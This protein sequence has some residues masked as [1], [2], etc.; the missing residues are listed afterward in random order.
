MCIEYSA[1]VAVQLRHKLGQVSAKDLIKTLHHLLITFTL[2]FAAYAL[3]L[4]P[5][6][7]LTVLTKRLN[8]FTENFFV[9]WFGGTSTTALVQ[10]ALDGLSALGS[11]VRTLVVLWWCGRVKG[12]NYKRRKKIQQGEQTKEEE[13]LVTSNVQF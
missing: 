8:V 5:Q 12:R 2:Q 4:F 13:N 7:R 9:H 1:C 6:S 11:N 3:L 10:V